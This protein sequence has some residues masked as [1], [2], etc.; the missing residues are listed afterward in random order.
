MACNAASF[1]ARG[2]A[3]PHDAD[4]YRSLWP[5]FGRERLSA[6]DSRMYAVVG[7]TFVNLESRYGGKLRDQLSLE[8]A[9]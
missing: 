5:E 2:F 1:D 4:A 6:V 9:A 3:N 7:E 8:V